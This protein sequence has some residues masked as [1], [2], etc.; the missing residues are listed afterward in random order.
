[1]NRGGNSLAVHT[2]ADPFN[3]FR[4]RRG[5]GDLSE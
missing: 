2:H 3:L 5:L 1:M 4:V